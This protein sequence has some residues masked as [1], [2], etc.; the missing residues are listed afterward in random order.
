MQL[1]FAHTSWHY[2]VTVKFATKI[3]FI[4]R[5]NPVLYPDMIVLTQVYNKKPILMLSACKRVAVEL[6]VTLHEHMK[7]IFVKNNKTNIYFC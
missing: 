2:E 7:F 1:L 6:D 4:Y 5:V 3:C